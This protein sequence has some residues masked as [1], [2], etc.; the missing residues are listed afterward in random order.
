[1]SSPAADPTAPPRNIAP[2]AVWALVCALVGLACCPVTSPVAWWLGWS[3][4]QAVRRGESAAADATVAKVSL[5]L[6]V[7]GT[8]LGLLGALV[9]LFAAVTMVVLAIPR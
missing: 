4:V 1:V 5:W 6:G 2:R 8:A 7:L 9:V 3:E